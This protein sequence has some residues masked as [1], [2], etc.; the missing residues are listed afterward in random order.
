MSL[1]SSSSSTSSLF[2]VFH[3]VAIDLIQCHPVL[4]GLHLDW[5]GMVPVWASQSLPC[6]SHPFLFL[7]P[8]VSACK[9][10][11]PKFRRSGHFAL[12]WPPRTLT[13]SMTAPVCGTVEHG[14]RHGESTERTPVEDYP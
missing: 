6:V 14:R 4:D 12:L 11:P 7:R 2:G 5:G 8:I 10:P 1:F 9:V 13:D 3:V